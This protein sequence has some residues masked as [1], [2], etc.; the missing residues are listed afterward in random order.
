MRLTLTDDRRSHS[1]S[2]TAHT[3]KKTRGKKR[4]ETL[5]KKDVVLNDFFF[6]ILLI[7]FNFTASPT[8]FDHVPKKNGFEFES[9]RTASM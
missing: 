1:Q 8:I 3:N 4:F 5:F 6:E 9:F 2:T 7:R